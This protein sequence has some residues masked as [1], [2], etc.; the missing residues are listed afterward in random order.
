MHTSIIWSEHF[1]ESNDSKNEV[2][3]GFLWKLYKETSKLACV[4]HSCNAIKL[5]V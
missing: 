3:G 5:K 1:S 4:A 2:N